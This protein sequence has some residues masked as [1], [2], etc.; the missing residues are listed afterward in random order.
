[1]HITILPNEGE[2]RRVKVEIDE[3]EA[4]EYQ[5]GFF[6]LIAAQLGKTPSEQITPRQQVEEELGEEEASRLVSE[7]VVTRAMPMVVDRAKI[8]YIGQPQASYENPVK[9]DEPFTFE[10]RCVETPRMELNSYEPVQIDFDRREVTDEEVEEFL[11]RVADYHP[12]LVADETQTEVKEDSHVSLKMKTT[13]NGEEVENLCFDEVSYELGRGDMPDGFDEQIIGMKPG[14]T[15][16]VNY[17]AAG[18]LRGMPTIRKYEAQVTINALLKPVEPVIDDE[19]V[20]RNIKGCDTLAEMRERIIEELNEQADAEVHD[21]ALYATANALSGRLMGTVPD[22]AFEAYY[23]K[24]LRDLR[25]AIAEEGISEQEYL[26]QQGIDAEQMK[27]RLMSQ[28]RE[29]IRQVLALDAMG[30]HLKMKLTGEEFKQHL[31]RASGGKGT[32]FEAHLKENGGM[33]KERETALR[34]KINEWLVE[35]AL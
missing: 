12:D 6:M 29:Q 30:R 20:A 7:H 27:A 8:D 23:R 2:F 1:M 25:E 11:Q 18:S 4:L 31:D 33:L 35:Q 5:K 3:K 32:D 10:L 16:V 28:T 15:R 9:D 19:W 21:Y 24:M 17:D 22:S 34:V 13:S 26:Q 14:E